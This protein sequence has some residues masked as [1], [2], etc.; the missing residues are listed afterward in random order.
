MTTDDRYLE[1]SRRSRARR[2]AAR[3]R[4]K[5]VRAYVLATAFGCIATAGAAALIIIEVV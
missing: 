1:S 2:R 4:A 5:D 3:E